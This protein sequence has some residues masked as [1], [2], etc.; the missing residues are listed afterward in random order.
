MADTKKQMEQW[1]VDANEMIGLQEKM[2]SLQKE[3]AFIASRVSETDLNKA[4]AFDKLTPAEQLV[5]KQAQKKRE[6]MVEIRAQEEKNLLLEEA[7]NKE[8]ATL[9]NLTNAKTSIE[10]SYT[11]FYKEEL[12]SRQ[13]AYATYI[14]AIKS[15]AS[16]APD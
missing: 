4:I 10:Q 2:A 11:K 13:D 3:S 6:L 12:Q 1:G 5:E 9:E 14:S 8:I 16:S 7:K 15:L